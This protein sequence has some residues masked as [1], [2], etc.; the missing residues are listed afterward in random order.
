[1]NPQP[2]HEE[3]I[4]EFNKQFHHIAPFTNKEAVI[5]SEDGSMP[6]GADKTQFGAIKS[7][8]RQTLAQQAK[9]ILNA[10]DRPEEIDDYM[11]TYAEENLLMYKEK[12]VAGIEAKYGKEGTFTGSFGYQ[13]IVMGI[14]S[15]Q[16]PED[17]VRD[18]I[19]HL[20]KE[21]E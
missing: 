18:G 20:I 2:A 13:G 3:W 6:F 19:I 16:T 11:E 5:Y 4:D 10:P 1:M 7:F 14:Q 12:L 9:D 17:K 8:I 21:R 15:F